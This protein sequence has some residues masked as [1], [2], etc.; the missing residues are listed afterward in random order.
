MFISFRCFSSFSLG[1]PCRLSVGASGSV[2]SYIYV[3]RQRMSEMLHLRLSLSHYYSPVFN[4]I[5]PHLSKKN[6]GSRASLRLITVI[7]R[8]SSYSAF[9]VSDSEA[10]WPW[11]S[12]SDLKL[13]WH[14]VCC[15]DFLLID[16]LID[17]SLLQHV[18][19]VHATNWTWQW[20]RHP[21]K[22]RK[23]R[24]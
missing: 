7:H 11:P 19:N 17:W 5:T 3:I 9:V 12:N 21:R 2:V 20:I 23:K 8:W 16:W 24:T 13:K 18:T 14:Q 15:D 6:K 1:V 22:K 10:P 4:L